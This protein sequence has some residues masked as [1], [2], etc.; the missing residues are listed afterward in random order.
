MLTGLRPSYLAAL[1]LLAFS[2]LL[3]AQSDAG[4]TLNGA[5][6][7]PSGSS[8]PAS[9][10]TVRGT[11]TGFTRVAQSTSA[12]LYS[13]NRLPVGQYEL[14]VEAAGFKTFTQKGITLTIGSTATIDLKLEVGAASETLS[15]TSDAP[16]VETTPPPPRA[17]WTNNRSSV[18]R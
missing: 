13:F 7:D 3:P 15:V 12:G 6:L 8:V 4:A 2:S 18:S 9:K 5:I 1:L 14:K 16:V 17:R 11:A 10:I